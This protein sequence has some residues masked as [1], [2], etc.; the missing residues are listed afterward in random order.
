M[1]ADTKSKAQRN[2]QPLQLPV[3]KHQLVSKAFLAWLKFL[4]NNIIDNFQFI[5]AVEDKANQ[6][7]NLII[8]WS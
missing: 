5:F 2:A 6:Q 1:R 8:S 3:Q 7:N 4:F